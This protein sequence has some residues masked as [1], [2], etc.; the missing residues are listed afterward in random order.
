MRI[1]G[2]DAPRIVETDLRERLQNELL[3]DRGIWFVEKRGRFERL[4][5][6]RA[7]GVE[8]LA[9]SCGT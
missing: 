5:A 1:R 8:C 6:D 3:A 4:G 7:Y 9:G 2:I